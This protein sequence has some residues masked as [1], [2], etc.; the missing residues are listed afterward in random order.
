MY[1]YDI[2][3]NFIENSFYVNESAFHSYKV[4]HYLNKSN[5]QIILD[6]GMY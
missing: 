3:W 5:L 4:H 6:S 2:K 1:L